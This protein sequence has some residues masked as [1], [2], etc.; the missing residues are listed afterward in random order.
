MELTNDLVHTCVPG[1][2]IVVSGVV[3]AMCIQE[4]RG[5]GRRNPAAK[6]MYLLYIDAISITR[7]RASHNPGES[8]QQKV[9]APCACTDWL[10][11]HFAIEV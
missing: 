11:T 2:V 9:G 6:S 10:V 4:K 1:D 3:K 8:G 7:E 5:G